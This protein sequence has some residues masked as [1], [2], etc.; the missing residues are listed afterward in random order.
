LINHKLAVF[1]FDSTLINEE[2]LDEIAD[3]FGKKAEVEQ[4]T[5]LGMNGQMD[6]FLSL[7]KRVSLLKGLPSKH[8]SNAYKKL[9]LTCGAKELSY[10]LKKM[11]YKLVIFS[12]GFREITSVFAKRLNFDADFA[13]SFYVQ[14]NFLTGDIGGE[15]MFSDSK[16]SMIKRLQKIM[17]VGFSN[18]LVCGDGANDASMFPFAKHKI[19]FCAKEILKQK[20]NIVIEKRDL[21]EILNYI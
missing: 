2:T 9:T 16:G 4:I 20:A 15:M 19:A 12:G 8:I 1:D 6:F 13:N 3:F 7:K 14:N 21:R 11:G 18:T 17:N 10:E 5:K